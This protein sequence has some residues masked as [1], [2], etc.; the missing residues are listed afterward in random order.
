MIDQKRKIMTNATTKEKL[1][2]LG[3]WKSAQKWAQEKTFEQ[4]YST[5][6]RGDWLCWLFA[7]TNPADLKILTLVK[8][9]QANTVRHLMTDERSL[10]AVDA[11]IA[12]GEG[13]IGRDEL[14]AAAT[15]ANAAANAAENTEY[16][17][18]K[19]AS[20]AAEYAATT[21]VA[22]TYAA[23]TYAA[24]AAGDAAA[25]CKTTT[26]AEASEYAA[27]HKANQQQTAD[28][29]RQFIPITKFNLSTAS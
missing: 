12:F 8:G 15:A 7:K 14:D 4:I 29:F 6:H 28:I 27:A 5:C 23:A 9:H 3:D 18:A 22:T 2:Q 19:Y 13:K 1:I 25:E 21:Y 10:K 20:E 16:A 17:G 11:A 24:K 26:Y